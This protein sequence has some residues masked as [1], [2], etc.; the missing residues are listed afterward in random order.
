MKVTVEML[1]SILDTLNIGVVATDKDDK[2]VVFNRMAGEI[3][4]QDPEAR[5]GTSI[6]RCHP[7]ES[8]PAVQKRISDLRN[9]VME[10]TEAWLDYRERILYEY[11]CPIWD[12]QGEY[13]GVLSEVHDAGDKAELLKRLGEW[14]DIGVSGVGKRAPRSPQAEY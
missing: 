11:I 8:E 9:R 2:I 4:Q 5:I 1:Q 14:K 7:K 13:L 10:R 12:E 6:L 3:L